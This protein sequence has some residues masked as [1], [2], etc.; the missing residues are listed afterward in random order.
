MMRAFRSSH[1]RPLLA[2]AIVISC[3]MFAPPV[4]GQAQPAKPEASAPQR[5]ETIV[6][7]NWTVTCHDS[8][9]KD[10]KRVCSANLRVTNNQTRQNVLIWEIGNDATGKPT[11]AL[12]TP[13]GVMIKEGVQLT[14]GTGKPRKVDY[15]LCDTRGCEAA[16]PFDAALSRELTA[17]SEASVVFVATNGQPISLKIPVKGIVEALPSLRN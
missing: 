3:G 17:A 9:S 6:Y 7:D 1:L 14:L 16:A 8:L 4:L 15:V 2:A 10:A 11:F 5:T 12:R 13:L